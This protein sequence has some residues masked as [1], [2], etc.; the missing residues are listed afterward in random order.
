VM[1]AM[2]PTLQ[3]LDILIAR[4]HVRRALTQPKAHCRDECLFSLVAVCFRALAGAK[5]GKW[6]GID[7]LRA[8]LK[9]KAWDGESMNLGTGEALLGGLQLIHSILPCPWQ[10][11]LE[12]WWMMKP[13]WL[14]LV[15]S[16]TT[17]SKSYEEDGYSWVLG[18]FGSSQLH[19][20]E[21]HHYGW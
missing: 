12:S 18:V 9:K 17:G 14:D 4:F 3:D 21:E 1:M 6:V 11:L 15:E 20:S 19:S 13:A 16:W 7:S 10:D 8:I 5:E 2:R